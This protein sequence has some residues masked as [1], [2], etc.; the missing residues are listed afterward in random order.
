VTA[1]RTRT[2]LT[3]GIEDLEE[4]LHANARGV[5]C[6]EAAVRLLISHAGWLLRDVFVTE[7][8]ETGESIVDCTPM[9]FIDWPAAVAALEAGRLPCSDSAAQILRIAA[10]IAGGLPV[11]LR[12]AV[13]GLDATNIV[14]VAQAVLHA[15]GHRE[16]VIAVREA[17]R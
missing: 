10:S 7:F 17:G 14:L 11:S 6:A 3:T 4:A 1:R 8:V 12:D 15:G 2:R 9:A 5:H 13:S 16:T